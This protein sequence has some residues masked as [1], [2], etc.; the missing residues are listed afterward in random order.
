MVRGQPPTTTLTRAMALGA[1]VASADGA[2][3]AWTPEEL[4]LAES[5]D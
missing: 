4:A 5:A 3:P 1:L 2:L